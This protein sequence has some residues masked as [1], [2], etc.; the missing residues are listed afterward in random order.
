[1]FSFASTR[2]SLHAGLRLGREN[3]IQPNIRSFTTETPPLPR[4][5][6]FARRLGY[7]VTALGV[8]YVV[9]TKYNASAVVRNL[10]TLWT[11]RFIPT[12]L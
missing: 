7:T 6:N 11:V 10:R 1:M 3:R 5:R 9:D 12:P 4:S 2:R 8:V